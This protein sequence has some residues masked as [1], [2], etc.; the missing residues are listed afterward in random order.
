MNRKVMGFV[1]CL[2][3]GGSGI[4]FAHGQ[5][6]SMEKMS[7]GDLPQPVQDTLKRE[8]GS[9]KVEEIRK[10]TDQ[11]GNEIYKAEIVRGDKGTDLKLSQDGKVLSRTS[12][13]EAGE[14]QRG[15]Q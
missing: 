2:A 7:L 8:A 5:S 9:S 10:S 6:S 4:A 3:L 1:A 11:S 14:H 13:N 15:E 12:H